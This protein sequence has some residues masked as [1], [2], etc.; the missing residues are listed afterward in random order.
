MM[1]SR[2]F[3]ICCLLWGVMTV[4]AQSERFCIAKDGK[5]ATIVVDENDWKGV[6]RAANDLSDDV[7]KVTGFASPI[8]NSQKPI[9]NS[10]IVGTIGKSR[11]IDQLIKQKI[12]NVKEIKGRWEAYKICVVDDRSA[13]GRLQGKNL[14]IAGS[15]KRGTIY[16]IYEISRRMGVSPWYWM[17]DAPVIHKDEVWYYG[18]GYDYEWPAVKY[19]G[20]FINDEWPSFG[21]WCNKHFGGVNSKAY[22]K[23]FELL[24]RLKANYFWP[25]MWATNF[26]EDDPESPRLADEMGIVMGTSHHEPMMRSHREYLKRK[27]EVGPWDYATNKERV[28]AFFREGMERNKAYDNLVTIGMRGDGDV[29]MG[30]GD[31]QENIKT[32][33]NVIDGQRKIIKDI[34]GRAD[35]VPQLWAIFTEVQRY[36]DAGFTVPD[37]VTLLFCDNNWGYIRR[38]GTEAERKRKGGLGLYYHIDMNGG[39]WNDRWVNT[40]TVPKLREQLNQAYQSGINRIWII[41]V[42]DLKPKEMPISF[43]MDYAWGPSGFGPYHPDPKGGGRTIYNDEFEWL[44]QWTASVLGGNYAQVA[45]EGTEAKIPEGIVDREITDE[46]AEIIAQY[47][48]LNLMRKPEVQVPG[49]FNYEEM[50]RLNNQW[51]SIVRRCERLKEQIPAEAQDAFYQLVYYPAVASAGVAM[52]YNAATMGD[53]ETVYEL[54]DQDRQLTDYYNKVMAGGKWDGMMLD[55]HIGYT[56]WS[57]PDKNTNPMD[58]GYKIDHDLSASKD[59]HEYTIAADDYQQ[60]GEG[61]TELPGLGRGDCC[62]GAVDVMKSYPNGDGPVL[63]YNINLSPT[64]GKG[65]VAIGILPTQDVYPARG[66]RLGVQIDDWPMATVDARQ[67]LHDEFGEYTPKNLAQSKVLK[68]LPPHNNLLLSGWRNGRK[69]LRRDEVFDNIRWLEVNFGNITPGKHK[70]K[71]ILIDPE[72]V[73]ESIVVNPDNNRYSYFGAPARK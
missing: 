47:S 39:P 40:T 14:V 69:M 41:N 48:K 51:Q 58:L 52:M 65:T 66:L 36:Y 72:I 50:L 60:M 20:I 67:G 12:L 42:G 53:A 54:M 30:K 22:E 16:G 18:Y 21:T 64:N 49:L 71:L 44:R 11:I 28:D 5:T 7:S 10:I 2:V 9:A 46:C 57:I 70:L 13:D 34:Y 31:D 24:L 59:T 43:I 38:K 56:K 4:S 26:N 35:A 32:L 61:W 68:P 37:D 63:E 55:N 19:R 1:R 27:D 33:K 62:V 25:A 29:A 6:L 3:S 15:D 23:I 17:A 45:F 73:V 8:A